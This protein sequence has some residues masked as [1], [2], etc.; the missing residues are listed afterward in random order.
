MKQLL[1]I[2]IFIFTSNCFGQNF[3]MN[4]GGVQQSGYFSV[5]PYENVQG[6]IVIPVEINGKNYRFILDTGA[7]LS[8]T[9]KLADELQAK[10]IT[11]LDVFDQSGKTDSMHVVT[12]NSLSIGGIEF[13]GIPALVDKTGNLIFECFRVDGTV[14]SNVLRNSIIQF[15][16]TDKT[17]TLTDDY[18]KLVLHKKHAV[19]LYLDRSQSSPYLW[20]NFKNKKDIREAVL[21]DSGDDGLYH[22]SLS[23][24][25]VFQKR[26]IIQSSIEGFGSNSLGMHGAAD[27]TSLYIVTIPQ[28]EVCN[29]VF[30]NIRSTTTGGIP[31]IGS[32]LFNYG[33]VTL[34]YRNKRFYF[35]P[36]ANNIMLDEK[37]M[38]CLP[39]IKNNK[40]IIGVIWD[41]KLSQQINIGDQVLS[42]DGID[43]ANPDPCDLFNNPTTG[44]E[45]MELQVKTNTGEIK[46]VVV[47]R[48]M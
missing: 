41:K 44:K 47:K 31:S 10:K 9:Q 13:S 37:F 1:N 8:I 5:I 24:F 27:D 46:T 32:K 28:M 34:D 25:E 38:E 12:V 18:R 20:I 15:S 19:K 7:P 42:I 40:V 11:T 26:R 17:V 48:S 36:F 29:V 4:Q 21:F 2:I 39:N 6:M 23:H 45:E 35:E 33:I 43:Y 22:L 3:T 14:G 30:N 16:S